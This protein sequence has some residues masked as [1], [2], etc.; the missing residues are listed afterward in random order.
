MR[1]VHDGRLNVAFCVD[2]LNIGGT[3][4]NAVR[5]AERL[6]R[7]RFDLRVVCLQPDGPLAGRYRAA[8]IPLDVFSPGSLVGTNAFR[9]GWRLRGYL[10]HHGIQIFHSHDLYSNWFGCPWARLAGTK[11]IASRRWLGTKHSGK[12]GTALTRLTY[13][14]AHVALANSPRVADYLERV[15]RVSRSRIA[16]VPNFLDECAFE[17]IPADQ[18]RALRDEFRLVDGTPTIG[19]VANLRPVKDHATLVRAIARLSPRWPRIRAI[20]VG[21][22]E[23]RP[24]LE[25][26]AAALGVAEHVVFAGPRANSPN[27]NGLFD[28][29]VLC[30]KREGLPNSILE[31]M[32]AGT[33]VVATDVGAVADAVIHG[34]TGLLV[35]ASDPERLA[36]ALESLLADPAR[37]GRLGAAG[38]RRAQAVYSPDAALRALEAVYTGL[39]RHDGRRESGHAVKDLAA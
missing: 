34:E 22:G 2:N 21:G 35:P 6:D 5:L 33:P 37:A 31:A 7:S 19:V 25:R 16:V 30:S 10:R 36:A 27:L 12:G 24:E 4:L 14:L 20:F 39:V 8:G 38:R 29:A 26:L 13:R 15:D 23:G 3:E 18:K 1:D 17:P 11:V 28:V 32:A 9:E